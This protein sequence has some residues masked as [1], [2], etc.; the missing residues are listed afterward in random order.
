MFGLSPENL[1]F[2]TALANCYSEFAHAL[3]DRAANRNILPHPA[4]KGFVMKLTIRNVREEWREPVE[5]ETHR[6]AA[7]LDKLLKRY[8]PDLVQLHADIEKHPRK[9]NYKFS[10]NL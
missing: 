1:Q 5:N 3:A 7:K 8:A 2:A 9:N 10:V 6:Q 4:R